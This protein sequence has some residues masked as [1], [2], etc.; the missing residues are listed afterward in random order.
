MD[1]VVA[2]KAKVLKN[3]KMGPPGPCSS[4]SG[5]RYAMYNTCGPQ[6]I[7]SLVIPK[8]GDNRA[9]NPNIAPLKK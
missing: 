4:R 6:D 1:V 3:E 8:L 9:N 5:S 7:I 2:D